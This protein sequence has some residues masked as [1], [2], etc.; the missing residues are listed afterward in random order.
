L[1]GIPEIIAYFYGGLAG[2]IISVAIIKKHYK[3]EK[4]F[5]IIFDISELLVISIMFLLIAAFI[6]VYIT[7]L[8]F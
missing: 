7:P 2:G 5:H 6:E 4:F 1:H 8:L 3:D